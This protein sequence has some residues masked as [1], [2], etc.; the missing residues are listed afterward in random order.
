MSVLNFLNTTNAQFLE[1]YENQLDGWDGPR[2]DQ[3]RADSQKEQEKCMKRIHYIHPVIEAVRQY[4]F[5]IPY[6]S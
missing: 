1:Y 3:M 6:S 5:N 2:V 4:R